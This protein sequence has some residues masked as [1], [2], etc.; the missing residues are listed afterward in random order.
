MCFFFP[1]VPPT[2]EHI[3]GASLHHFSL[4]PQINW[5][6][7]WFHSVSFLVNTCWSVFFLLHGAAGAITSWTDP[8][9]WLFV[10]AQQTPVSQINYTAVDAGMVKNVKNASWCPAPS[11]SKTEGRKKTKKKDQM[12]LSGMMWTDAGQGVHT[13]LWHSL[14]S[15]LTSQVS[16]CVHFLLSPTLVHFVLGLLMWYQ[17][18]GQH[19]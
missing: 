6:N 8:I 7:C 17:T 10:P 5:A 1:T 13:S 11:L 3:S 14:S 19:H 4:Q 12:Y 18:P 2:H 15:Y 16:H 9:I